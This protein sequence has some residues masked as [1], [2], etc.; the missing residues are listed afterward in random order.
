MER[1]P[2]HALLRTVMPDGTIYLFVIE[3][4]ESWTIRRDDIII[5]SGPSD[6]RGIDRGTRLYLSLTR[7]EQRLP[8]FSDAPSAHRPDG[9]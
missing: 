6:S 7:I 3:A 8:L 1:G 9:A 5:D 2:T 4:D